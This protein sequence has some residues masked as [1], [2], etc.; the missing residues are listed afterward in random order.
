MSDPTSPS[1]G[2]PSG[3]SR[4]AFDK[5]DTLVRVTTVQAWISL[6]TL[7]AICIGAVA[8]AFLHRV[9]RKVI[10]EGILLIE[11]DRLSQVRALGNGRL[12]RLNVGLDDRVKANDVIGEIA[13]QDLKDLTSET[14]ARLTELEREDEALT[15]FEDTERKTQDQ[16]IQVLQDALNKTIQNS[17]EGLQIANQ[18]VEGSERLRK[19]QQLSNPDRL[20]DRQ[21]KYSIQNDLNN[22]YSKLAEL[23][24]TRRD[25]GKPADSGTSSAP[26]RDQQAGDTARARTGEALTNLPDRGP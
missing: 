18:I 20:K 11:Q 7:F 16:A 17:L 23:Q 1:P 25:V 22:G 8:F 10:G 4:I 26:A 12:V 6:V 21:Q 3:T 15:Q 9:P 2:P 14:R 19:L 24:L 5:F 13:Q